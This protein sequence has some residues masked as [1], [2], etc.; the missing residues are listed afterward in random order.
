MYAVLA[1]WLKDVLEDTFSTSFWYSN[2]AFLLR[3][4]EN[5]L[6]AQSVSNCKTEIFH[7]LLH[8]LL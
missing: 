6:P 2:L 3:L 1:L 4:R 7:F 8:F 5:C